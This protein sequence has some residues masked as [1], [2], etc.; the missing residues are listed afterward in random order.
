V[1]PVLIALLGSLAAAALSLEVLSCIRAYVGGEGLYSKGQK[2]AAFYLAQY[3]QSHEPEDF[4]HY[5][6]AIAIPLGDRQARLALQQAVPDLQAARLGFL[7]GGNDPSDVEGMVRTFL[8]FG[9]VGPIRRAIAIWEQ[10]D[11]STLRIVALAQRMRGG[12][13]AGSSAA[14]EAA[15]R[16]QLREINRQLTALETDFSATLGSAARRTR[17]ALILALGLGALLTAVL[18]VRGTRARLRERDRITEMY[19]ALSRTSQLILRVSDQGQLFEELC[20]ICVTSSGMSLAAVSLLDADDGSRLELAAAYGARPEHTRALESSPAPCADMLLGPAAQAL[21]E[22]CAQVI[23]GLAVPL[24]AH[25]PADRRQVIHCRS[26]AAFPLRRQGKVVGALSVFS[27]V[28][29]FFKQD[30]V[31]L[32]EQ[33]AREVSFALENLQREQERRHQAALLA[34]QNRILNLVASGADLKSI[35]TAVAQFLEA[36]LNGGHCALA[37][38]DR[39]GNDYAL[40][41]APNVP[42]GLEPA[43]VRASLACGPCAEAIRTGRMTQILDLNRHALAGAYSVC[44]WPIIGNQ[45]QVLGALALYHAESAALRRVDP[46][47]VRICAD[48][49]AIAI[50]T[51]RAAE[52]IW[53]LA[54][55]DE[56]TSLPNRLHFNDQLEHALLRA[57]RNGEPVGVLF[58]DIDR[59]KVINDTFGHSAGDAVLCQIAKRFLGCMR[60]TDTLARVGGDEFIVLVEH[61]KESSDLA[62]FAQKLLEVAADAV[63]INGQECHLSGSIGISIYPDDGQ[64]GAALLKNAD[65][66]MYRAKSCGRNNYQ[67]F[68]NE[69]DDHSPDRLVL[70]NQLHRALARREFEV[71]YQPKIDI[72]TRRICGAEALVRWAHPSRG[73]LLPGEFI[74]VAEELGLVGQIGRLVLEIVCADA[75]RWL[76]Q[77]LAQIRIAVNLSARQFEDSRLLEDLDHALLQSGCDPFSLEFEITE[78]A[79]MTSPERALVMLEKIKEHGVTLAIDDFGTGHSSLAYLKRFP[80]D[81]LKIDRTFVRDIAVD[82]NDLAITRAILAMGHSMGLRVVAEGV[83]TALQMEMLERMDC[84]EY[85]G[86]LFSGAVPASDFERFLRSAAAPVERPARPRRLREAGAL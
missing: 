3:A 21:R 56:L 29:Q 40:Y 74:G 24:D 15:S 48:L 37:A 50:E 54:H 72:R 79:L 45:G 41:V 39:Q 60:K 1:A 31:E 13:E 86:Y 19:A 53:H 23:N 77:R 4:Q 42:Q 65:I 75:K 84:D 68:A 32:M 57:K 16:A 83:E 47:L 2:N 52:R 59:F 30:I 38:L 36:R 73:L 58:L 18:C 20:R 26:L 85:Q 9:H 80:V 7:G 11:Q 22:D 6:E 43:T 35:F 61:F 34:D 27:E 28:E 14:D 12:F 49:A 8:W 5:T 44:A 76:D 33:L 64:D 71:H 62:G 10:A 82:P 70:E 46:D 69:M 78:S 51:R 67:F 17:S 66:A 25:A 81:S 55:H 63:T